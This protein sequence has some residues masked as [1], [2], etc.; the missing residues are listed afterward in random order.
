MILRVAPA[1]SLGLLQ[2]RFGGYVVSAL[3]VLTAVAVEVAVRPL[4]QGRAPLTFFAVAVTLAAAYGGLGPGILAT[5]LSLACVELLFANSIFSFLTSQPSVVSFCIVSIGISF[6]IDNFQKRNR[7]L[8]HAK[9]LL[10]SA[11]K[12]LARRSEDL[13][14]SNQELKRFAYALS[15]DLQSPLR[16]VS[17][18]AGLLAESAAGKLDEESQETMQ[19]ILQGAHQAQDMI[20]RLLE[21]AVADHSARI[22]ATT[23]LNVVLANALED[24]QVAVRESGARVA[25]EKLPVV[26]GD[27]DRLRQVFLNLLNNAIKYHGECCP[28]IYVAA[29]R[30]AESWVIS[31]RDN[32]IGIDQRYAEKIFGLFERLHTSESYAGSGIGL[33]ICRTIIERHGGRIWVESELGRGSIFSFSLPLQQVI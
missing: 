29:R 4:F 13:I 20:H 18:C 3:L 5:G 26:Q 15:H 9:D 22:K 24:V 21:Y 2:W 1:P 14:Q 25:S 32:G 10:E 28:E 16:T 30:E 12:E 11:N 7:S 27:A 8:A 6:V 17:L 19:L 23:D 31:V 33:A